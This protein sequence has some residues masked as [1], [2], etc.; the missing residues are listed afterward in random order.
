MWFISR[1]GAGLRQRAVSHTEFED[2]EWGASYVIGWSNTIPLFSH[3]RED[4][5][6]S[7]WNWRGECLVRFSSSMYRSLVRSFASLFNKKIGKNWKITMLL[8]ITFFCFCDSLPYRFCTTW[9]RL[10]SPRRFPFTYS[11]AW[12]PIWGYN[13][14]Y[15]LEYGV[16][17]CS[18]YAL[19][20]EGLCLEM[21]IW[22]C[23]E[24]FRF[25]LFLWG[26]RH[27]F[28]FLT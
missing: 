17:K 5:S 9:L 19:I 12:F 28:F 10:L 25:L 23:T 6:G 21:F 2:S 15:C 26:L 11:R 1:N 18:L 7:V 13:F 20:L 22:T 4:F 3:R 24:V 27:I 14:C 8:Y 16:R